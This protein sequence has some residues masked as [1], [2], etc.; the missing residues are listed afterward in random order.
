MI[1][2]RA[3]LAASD[4]HEIAL[5]C[6][7]A[8]VDAAAPAAA[9][10]SAVGRDSQTLTVGGTTYDLDEYNEV[11]VVGGGKAAG[12][13]TRALES[14]LGDTLSGGHVVV[15]QAIDTET[16]RSSVGDHPLP[17]DR[18]VAATTEMLKK[19][20][21]TDEDTL[22]LLVLTGGASALLSAP[23]GD[24]T[25]DDLQT[26]TDRLLSGG[27]PIAEIN[28]VRKHLSD[29]KGGQ[30][31]RRAT[32]ATVAGVLISDV[33]G[34]DLSTIG[35]GPSVPD[36]T[37]YGDALDVFERYDLTPPPA[38]HD[39]LEAGQDD[40]LSETPFP[41]D[42][43]FDRVTNHLIGDNATALDAAAA[44][45]RE[46]GYEALVL[47]SRLRG[48]AREVA[49]PLVA[50]AEEARATGT[51]VEPPAVL[52][53]GGE[54]TVTVTEDGGQGGPNQEFVLSG[55]LAHDGD[56]VIAAVD[57]DGEDGSSD[58][59]GAIADA[60]IIDDRKQARD[61]LLANDA[62]SYLSEIGATVETGPT[63]TNVNDLVILVI[64]DPNE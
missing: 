21:E 19:V 20:D 17:S 61:A 49:K 3:A 5:D 6:I 46:A 38:V 30:I 24:L 28:A 16:V 47:T 23:A 7:E 63:G 9:T 54:S 15:S 55:A 12:G 44:V 4:A 39:H 22:V 41:D 59:A 42:S 11:A 29:L 34:N 13:V 37:T 57:T 53:A 1:C 35:S 27:V 51:P 36:E 56:A 25:L 33:V 58:A 8:A 31:A 14:I 43:V 48:E 62:G 26:T 32:P 10:K 64:P 2:N 40:R 50:I 60:S 52:L 18:N 45:A